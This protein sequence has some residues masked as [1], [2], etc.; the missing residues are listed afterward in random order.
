MKGLKG[1]Q[2]LADGSSRDMTIINP[3]PSLAPHVSD[4]DSLRGCIHLSLPTKQIT[5]GCERSNGEYQLAQLCNRRSTCKPDPSLATKCLRIKLYPCQLLRTLINPPRPLH[6]YIQTSHRLLPKATVKG[7]PAAQA[8][9]GL[10][11]TSAHHPVL[12]TTNSS[13]S[14]IRDS[15]DHGLRMRMLLLSPYVPWIS[16][17]HAL[18]WQHFTANLSRRP[19]SRQVAVKAGPRLP[20]S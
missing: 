10:P 17:D 14:S 5:T 16:S 1:R 18:S 13:G 6:P 12:G 15:V 7:D 2:S 19:C 4:Y 9:L 20:T 3:D 8:A 11:P